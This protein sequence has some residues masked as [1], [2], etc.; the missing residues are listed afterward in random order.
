MVFKEE[1]VLEFFSKVEQGVSKE[2]IVERDLKTKP[3]ENKT[4]S[5][6]GP[7]RAGKTFYLFQ[8]KRAHGGI[9]MDFESAEFSKAEIEDVIKIISLY[10]RYFERKVSVIYLDEIQ[11][12]KNWERLARTLLNYGYKLYISGSSSKL[13]SKEIAT[14][15][16]GRS[17]TYFLL[18]F[19]FREFLAAKGF[20]IKK[21]YT[22]SEIIKI[23]K[24]LKDYLDFGGFPEVVLKEEKEKILK[25]Y[26]E[27]AFYKDFVERHKIE[28]MEVAK[29]I[30]EYLLQ[31][32]SK[33]IS[34]TKIQNFIEK[35][36]GIKTRSTI[37]NY[38]D[39]LEDSLLVFFIERFEKSIYRRK[40][41]PKKVYICD[42]GL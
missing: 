34:V 1:L 6:I 36:L 22:L 12:L 11:N 5:I 38:L 40:F 17:L 31:N 26:L 8:K 30:F 24:Y 14:Q 42:I 27:L 37:Y 2:K 23:K 33:E 41:F 20:K 39:K 21:L 16:R 4:I 32:F 7:R 15:L 25:E 18:P 10:E 13:L 29:I 35:T 28:S 19:S 9:Y 3:I